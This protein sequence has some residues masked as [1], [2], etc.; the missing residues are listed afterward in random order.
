MKRTLVVGLFDEAPDA[1]QV[2]RQLADSPLDLHDVAVLHRDS[3]VQRQLR[4]LAGVPDDRTTLIAGGIGALL[5]AALGVLASTAAPALGPA[6]NAAVGAVLGGLS[7]V[8]VSIVASPLKIPAE[9]RDALAQAVDEGASVVIVKAEGLPTAT[10]IGDLF[11]ASGARNLDLP[12]VAEAFSD[13]GG[14]DPLGIGAE[15]VAAAVEASGAAGDAMFL[16]PHRRE[17]GGAD[18]EDAV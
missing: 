15:G 14:P 1:G 10:A 2:L 11:R 4:R 8:V 16:P 12:T 3:D 6:L 18:A 9:H 5:G 13:N 17:Q 7:A